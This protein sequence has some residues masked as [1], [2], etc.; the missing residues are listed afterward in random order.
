MSQEITIKM[1]LD[2]IVKLESCC[3]NFSS[4]NGSHHATSL[5]GLL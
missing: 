1:S 3:D 4:V 5:L 2:R